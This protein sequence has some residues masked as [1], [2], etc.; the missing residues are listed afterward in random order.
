MKQSDKSELTRARILEGALKEFGERDYEAASVNNICSDNGISKGLIYHNFKNKDE[1]YLCCV[2]LCFKSFTEFL[3]G[4]QYTKGGCRVRMQELMDRRCE[5]FLQ[6]PALANIFFG[7]ILKAPP[8]L[9]QDIKEIRSEFDKFN[10]QRFG[11]IISTVKLRDGISENDALEC[12]FTVQEM[13]NGYFAA[14]AEADMKTSIERHELMMSKLIN[15][16][17]YGMIGEEQPYECDT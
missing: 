4:G 7:T 17:L 12:F 10:S 1:L 8:H 9:A 15:I 16:M 3:Q 6:N 2:E 13:F 14:K 11:E 5:F